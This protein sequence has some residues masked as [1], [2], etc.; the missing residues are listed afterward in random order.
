MELEAKVFD[1]NRAHLSLR[2]RVYS[3]GIH[4]HPLPDTEDDRKETLPLDKD[5]LRK[6]AGFRPGKPYPHT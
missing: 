1:L 3:A 6:I 5:E 2:G 4:K